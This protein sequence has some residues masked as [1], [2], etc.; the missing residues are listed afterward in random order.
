LGVEEETEEVQQAAIRS[1]WRAT[2]KEGRNYAWEEE[3]GEASARAVCTRLGVDRI[4]PEGSEGVT[5]VDRLE[6]SEKAWRQR[7]HRRADEQ[8]AVSVLRHRVSLEGEKVH[9]V[10]AG[11]KSHL[12]EPGH[13]RYVSLRRVAGLFG[14]APGHRV[15]VA[16]EKHARTEAVRAARH[17][18]WAKGKRNE[19]NSAMRGIAK[20]KLRSM[21]GG[22]VHVPTAAKAIRAVMKGAGWTEGA[23]MLW[24]D[25]G[26]GVGMT[27]AAAMKAAGGGHFKYVA[28]AEEDEETAAVLRD[29]W[30]G[31]VKV[32][33]RKA[34]HVDWG[35]YR[36]KLNSVGITLNCGTWSR[37]PR[38]EAEEAEERKLDALQEMEE[39]LEAL[40]RAR[41]DLV[42]IETVSDVLDGEAWRDGTR[43]LA[44]LRKAMPEMTWRVQTLSAHRHGAA[45]MERARAFIG[46]VRGGW[47]GGGPDQENE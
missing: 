11:N 13:G 24:A 37:R 25:V 38:S 22:G 19:K 6:L 8:P 2:R 27:A 5:S 23:R 32:H 16:L 12:F 20:S 40:E 35:Q 10:T 29:A 9:T 17:A 4:C 47:Q 15:T 28:A 42:I 3:K 18:L 45:A 43:I 7:C 14:L 44:L 34:E 39:V 31:G 21:L 36:G 33:M 26:S 30:G 46:G 1:F 41:P